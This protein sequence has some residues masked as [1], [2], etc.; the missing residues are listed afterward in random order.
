MNYVSYTSGQSSSDTKC[1]IE[2]VM[3]SKIKREVESDT[4]ECEVKREQSVIRIVR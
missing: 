4:E 1:N 2:C 3:G